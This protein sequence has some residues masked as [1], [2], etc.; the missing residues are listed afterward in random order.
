MIDHIL[1]W[2]LRGPTQ[3]S[4]LYRGLACNVPCHV[5]LTLSALPLKR[6]CGIGTLWAW[7]SPSNILKSRLVPTQL[8]DQAFEAALPL[9]RLSRPLHRLY[10]RL[11]MFFAPGI[12][13][14]I[15]K[16]GFYAHI[17][18]RCVVG[19][20]CFKLTRTFRPAEHARFPCT[21]RGC[22]STSLTPSHWH[23]AYR[24]CH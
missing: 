1:V 12:V 14:L 17:R 2:K 11:N 4:S 8:S 23:Q 15:S 16:R 20:H 7:E 6:H 21:I 18:S 9:P 10:L 5:A 13:S 19:N 22:S 24:A 3:T